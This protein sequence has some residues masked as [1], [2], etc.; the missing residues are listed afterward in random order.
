ME[1]D[2]DESQIDPLTLQLVDLIQDS[3]SFTLWWNT[4][5]EGEDSETYMNKSAELF[6]KQIT[7]EEFV[8]QLQTMN[9]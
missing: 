1:V 2:V 3:N 4:L 6:A 7:P 9:E 8:K 5:L